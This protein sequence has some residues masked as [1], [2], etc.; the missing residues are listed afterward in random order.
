MLT[1]EVPFDAENPVSIA[2]MHFNSLL[3]FFIP[4]LEILD[5]GFRFG[6]ALDFVLLANFATF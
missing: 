2:V 3:P 1:G 5:S 6:E 4:F